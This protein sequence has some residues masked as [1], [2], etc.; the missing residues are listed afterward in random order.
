MKKKLSKWLLVI[1]VL[2][3]LGGGAV[4][5]YYNSLSKVVEFED[6]LVERCVRKELG[7]EADEPITVKECA[8][9][10][11]LL[12]DCDLEFSY[13]TYY[14]N[15][16]G[17]GNA[18]YVDLCDLKYMTG[19]K[20][21]VIDNELA[22]DMLVN[23]DAL[24]KCSKLEKLTMKYNA[25]NNTYYGTIPMGYKY[26]ADI[27][28]ELPKLTYINI[29]YPVAKGHQEM[30]VGNNEK[31]KFEDDFSENAFI[32]IVA[33]S[34]EFLVNEAKGTDEYFKYWTYAY[35]ENEKQKQACKFVVSN[36][37]E[38][39]SLLESLPKDTEDIHIEYT[40]NESLDIKGLKKFEK[41]KTLSVLKEI[42]ILKLMTER[43]VDC[44][45]E[46]K[47]LDVLANNKELYSL[48]LSGINVNCDD[49]AV[50][51]Q[52]Q[53]VGL[54][55]CVFD[56]PE[57]LVKLP[58]LSELV[59][60]YNYCEDL[61]SYILDNGEKF[62]KLKYLRLL[63]REESDYKG[64]ELYPNLESLVIGFANGVE[65][66]DYISKCSNL[67]YLFFE[68]K[69]EK[70]DIS[71]LADIKT[72]KY[73][74][75]DALGDLEE[76]EGVE[77]IVSKSGIVSVVLPHIE[78]DGDFD[79]VNSWIAAAIDNSTLSCFIPDKLA[80]IDDVELLQKEIDYIK[81]YESEIMCKFNDRLML[82]YPERY[83]TIEDVLESFEN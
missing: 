73:L 81:L 30:L 37:K 78:R 79:D 77:K 8:S 76:L 48:S 27:I 16:S 33:N 53:E 46:L 5:I 54:H 51:T 40:G 38:F 13:I 9:V 65:K 21:L 20:E 71:S 23:L 55:N 15:A 35:N 18:N 72:L 50:L 74:Y 34:S 69:E 75:I 64:I 58:E 66:V 25:M 41:L 17:I 29:G 19:L 31:L 63:S 10:E 3:V 11:Y 67:K 6:P 83:P 59:V 43:H 80:Y 57:F 7:K 36:Q 24:K 2:I 42:L 56:N 4:G 39:D 1:L 44:A 45:V 52:I 68:T 32:N 62:K 47:N 60:N 28:D 14:T 26:L 22:R 49:M 61:Q 12:I 70:I 82:V